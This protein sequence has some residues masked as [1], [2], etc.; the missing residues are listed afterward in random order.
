[1]TGKR[2]RKR[3]SSG[4]EGQCNSQEVQKGNG[5]PVVKQA[6]L[7]QFYP[8]VLTLRDYL[9]SKLP[10][11]SKVRRKK[12]SSL[13]YEKNSQIR[14]ANEALS[15][16]LDGT[17]VGVS[18]SNNDSG[19][20]RWRQWTTFSQKAD[21]STSM[22]ADLSS[23]G[24]YSQS[25]IVDFAI[26]LLFSKNQASNGRLNHLLCQGFRRDVSSRMVIREENPHAAIPGVVST[27]PNSHV[28]SMKRAPWPQVL[29]LV[30]KEGER[31]MI[32]L[33]LDCGV[34][35]EVASGRGVYH[36][37]CGVPLNDLQTLPMSIG[38]LSADL[39]SLVKKRKHVGVVDRC[40]SSIVFVRSRMLYARAPSNAQGRVQ[41]GLKHIHV[42]NR[43]P[44]KARGSSGPDTAGKLLPPEGHS[45]IA[46]STIYTMMYLFPRQ[47][48]LHNVFT[49]QTDARQTVQAYMD[50]TLREDEINA[51]YPS[52]TTPKIP[53]RLRGRAIDLARKLQ[54]QHS[55]C[56]YKQLI[57]HYCPVSGGGSNFVIP[58]PDSQE[59]SEVSAVFKTQDSISTAPQL[60]NSPGMKAVIPGK[61][62]SMMLHATPQAM[63]SAFC[64]AVLTR[65]IPKEFWGTGQVQAHNEKIFSHNVHRFIELRRFEN[66]TL[67]ELSQGLQIST[68]EWLEP[69]NCAGNK[70]AKSD[71]NKRME[72]FHEFLYY[73]F[74]SILIPLI[75]TNF[76]VTESNIHKYRLFYFRHDVWRTL[77]EP[78][79]AAL[80]LTMFEEMKLE[81]AHRLLESRPLGFSQLRLLPKETGLR[82]I[83]N[84]RRRTIKRGSK[85]FLGSSINSIL[86]PV[87]NAFTYEKTRNPDRLGATLA[88]V[89]DIY[90]KLKLFKLRHTTS[91]MPFYFVK[92]DVKAAFDTIPQ[93]AVV[94][95]MSSL[96]SESEYRISKHVEIKP[97]ENFRED[98]LG[99][100]RTKPIRRWV[101]TAKKGTNFQSFEAAL[102]TD[103]AVKKKHMI[104]VENIVGKFRDR[105]ELLDLLAEHVQRNMVKIGKKFYRQKEGIPQGSVLSSLLCNYFYGDLE[106]QHLGFLDPEQSLLLR[107]IDDFLLVTTNK[108][109]AKQF[110]Q[111][112]HDGLPAYGVRVNPDKTLLN[113][114]ATINNKKV[115][116][117]VGTSDFPYCGSFINTRTLNVTRDR[118][119]RKDLDTVDSLTVEFSKNPGKN[120][121]RKVLNAFK[122]QGHAMFLDTSFNSVQTV[123]SNVHSAFVETASKMWIYARCLPVRKQPGTNLLIK[124]ISDL[125]DLAFALMKSKSKNSKNIGYKCALTKVQVEWLAVNAFRDVLRK[126]QTKY[127]KTLEWLDRRVAMLRVKEGR[128]CDRM[129]GIVLAKAA[130]LLDT[131]P[132]RSLI[133]KCTVD[134]RWSPTTGLTYNLCPNF[135]SAPPLKLSHDPSSPFV[136]CGCLQRPVGQEPLELNYQVPAHLHPSVITIV[137]GHDGLGIVGGRKTGTLMANS[138][139][140]VSE[141]LEMIIRAYLADNKRG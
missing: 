15:A 75:R 78:A 43:Y 61:Q 57:E 7:V 107:Y 114:E 1:M 103:L 26:W 106:A 116:R 90:E 60:T 3:P 46:T 81:R 101:A 12:I 49:S 4:G 14:P 77:A 11:T 91:S 133:D 30:G 5:D 80:K 65:L 95:L 126:R 25:E 19:D 2:K 92:V 132:I 112:M 83:M 35:L 113:F 102:E 120:F 108:S 47:F 42:L 16:F 23:V 130:L 32:D 13:G 44:L 54:I 51:K 131:S 40:L 96:L 59:I 52:P 6:L 73:I 29:A 85:N 84:L 79:I 24:S 41:F 38:K 98:L 55:R 74:D 94:N 28:T 34:F 67:H 129:S 121:H 20:E 118:E 82:P 63:V 122:I 8:Q 97:G 89:G 48:G 53:K 110:L 58:Q 105:E 86:A 64:R 138:I 10:S 69:P 36:Q 21:E 125:I 22:F 128:A 76:H 37:L 17:L 88:S 87:F 127:R 119:R 72:I 27:Y 137:A 135:L 56:S 31:A 93:A 123:I 104:F 136:G 18:V 115:A 111:I 140:P 9:L 124:T 70:L 71:L 100:E 62:L 139:Q 45:S 66:L 134:Y 33:I 99:R 39:S 117:L 68:I 141:N 109:H 50:Y